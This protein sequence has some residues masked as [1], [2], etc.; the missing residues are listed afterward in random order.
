MLIDLIPALHGRLGP[1]SVGFTSPGLYGVALVLSFVLFFGFVV[2]GLAVLFT[3]PRLL[4]LV[5]KP[6]RVY[7]LYASPSS[8]FR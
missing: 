8:P 2:F 7:P 5:Y 6:D 3:V 4:N 1:G